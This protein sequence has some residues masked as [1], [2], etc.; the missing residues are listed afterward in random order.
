[1]DVD[2]HCNTVTGFK[3][4]LVKVSNLNKRF[5]VAGLKTQTDPWRSTK[6]VCKIEACR[7]GEGIRCGCESSYRKRVQAGLGRGIQS[8]LMFPV[9]GTRRGIET[10]RR[11]GGHRRIDVDMQM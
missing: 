9:V 4:D 8:N 2:I 11:G 5:S 7:R 1:M 3:L 10:W 6:A